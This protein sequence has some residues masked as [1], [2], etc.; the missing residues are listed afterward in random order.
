MKLFGLQTREETRGSAVPCGR[1]LTCLLLSGGLGWWLMILDKLLQ[2]KIFFWPEAPV[3]RGHRHCLP[4]S[5]NA[6]KQLLRPPV[7]YSL[8]PSIG[9]NGL[10]KWKSP[11]FSLPRVR[12][13]PVRVWTPGR[14]PG[15]Q[16]RSPLGWSL[17][18]TEM[19]F[20]VPWALGFVCS[21]CFE[22]ASYRSPRSRAF[23]LSF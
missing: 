13:L 6:L 10:I 18:V 8:N 7:N 19:E 3:F 4:A 16:G 23:T 22:A 17:S 2:V 20:L 1:Q 11:L 9:V 5:C 14:S 21:S 15:R 12:R